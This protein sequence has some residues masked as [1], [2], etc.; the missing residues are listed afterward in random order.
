MGG[1]FVLARKDSPTGAP[2]T[3][4]CG[5]C[6]GCKT[7]RAE[8]WAVRLMHEASLYDDNIFLTLT[9]DDQN[10]PD[11]YS[12]SVREVQ[13]FIKKLR[14]HLRYQYKKRLIPLNKTKIRY[15]AVGEYG[16]KGGRP[17]YHIIIFNYRPDDCQVWRVTDRGH[18]CFRSE[19]IHDLWGKGLHEI[20]TVTKQSSR[21]VGQ[22]SQKKLG[23]D[24]S[25]EHYT[26]L[27]P[28]TGEIVHVHPEFALMSTH[29]GIGAGWFAKYERD[30]FPHDFVIVEGQK[31]SVP[32]YYKKKLR[33][34]FTCSSA[35]EE[36]LTVRDDFAPIRAK[37]LAGARASSDDRTPERLAV[38]E[39]SA[40]LR[41][42]RFVRDL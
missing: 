42:K 3:V 24:N 27:H 4:A 22:Y 9:Y 12:V 20:G 7:A 5:R 21:Y 11:D 23:G 2:M 19:V 1:Q 13:L 8:S 6:R 15:F 40:E 33:G 30:V 39:E 35:D 38:R 14:A 32:E 18:T 25:H 17:H 37:R 10:L 16:E 29:P 36:A 31:T 34:R 26:R 41:A 28:H